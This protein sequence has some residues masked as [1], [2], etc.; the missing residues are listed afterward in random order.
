MTD[1]DADRERR[2]LTLFEA[3]LAVSAASRPT[4][5]ARAADG[6]EALLARV[7]S[8]LAAHD[9]AALRT[10]AALSELE[11][12]VRPERVGSYRIDDL[13]GRGGMG[14]VYRAHRDA[15]DFDHVVAVK[16]IKPGLLSESLIDRFR[17]E[18]QMLAGL[19]HPNIARLYD[20]GET[21]EGAP[22]LV[23]EYVDGLPLVTWLE[24]AR[25]TP[26][27]RT[28]LFLA[29]CEAVS[30][31][32]ARLVVHRD[33][34]P[35]NV[36]VT[37][38]GAPRLIDF[39]IAR[40]AE[41]ADSTRDRPSTP[42]LSLT[43]G[44][45]APERSTGGPVTTSA[46]LY[47]LGKL[48]TLVLPAGNDRDLAA[49]AA[50]ATAHERTDRYPTVDALAADVVAWRDGM[51]VAARP[52]H[53]RYVLGK[54]LRRHRLAAMT[55]ATV[56]LLLTG[57]LAATLVANRRA[58]AARAEANMRFAQTRGIAR[59]LLFDTFDQVSRL[60]G[61]TAARQRLAQTGATYLD[62]LARSP[63]APTDVRLEAGR[64]F[65]RLAE[66]V[67]GGQA[68]SLARYGDGP[69]LLAR[70]EAILLPLHRAR[71]DDPAVTL[72]VAALLLEQSGTN[73][74]NSGK[75]DLALAQA[76]R[77]RAMLTPIARSGPVA[78]GAMVTALQAEGDSRQW[79]DRYD[80][81]LAL[82][83][84]AEAFAGALPPTLRDSREVMAARSAN[85]RL[86]GEAAH[87][88]KRT[89]E[90]RIAIDA[91]IAINRRLVA[92]DPG[93]PQRTRKLINALRYA[94]IVHRTNER[95]AQARAAID[96]AAALAMRVSERD[97][98]DAGQLTMLAAVLEVRAQI[99]GDAG[100]FGGSFADGETVVATHRRLVALADNA[101]GARRSLAQVLRTTGGNRYNGRDY[102]GA[103]RSW[104]ESRDI[105]AGMARDGQL[106]DRDR[107]FTFAEMKDYVARA[108][109]AGGPRAALGA[110]V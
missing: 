63:D 86:L 3:A 23:M 93:N 33:L 12:E 67:G 60:P 70:S 102:A 49:I 5:L 106:S 55:A 51:P 8:L 92:D 40:L 53:R 59:T 16:V 109:D 64:G 21:A 87:K 81:A 97:P 17:G 39:G 4:L 47:S 71:P 38:G 76:R 48:M 50:R 45:A 11:P 74:Y 42:S 18:R 6:D 94:A 72:A 20:G 89:D 78:A 56:L 75:T 101:V 95:D 66:V 25:P 108:C 41:D 69:A 88:L 103:C 29:M 110:S 22:Y 30:F 99:L 32:H 28:A 36:L 90:A 57:A 34:T 65:L 77:A 54:F 9:A 107:D 73:L 2:A 62:A 104:R 91:A 100:D 26:A 24:Q 19:V 13:L 98:D 10:G 37:A 84:Q 43:P 15:G 46:D 14:S 58:E 44:Y 35:S 82:H 80:L 31:A 52:A 1:A 79:A 83:R 85:L 27:K 61:S 105:M 96:E 7:R 68:G